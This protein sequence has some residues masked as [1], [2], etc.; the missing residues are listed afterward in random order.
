MAEKKMTS[1]EWSLY[2][3]VLSCSVVS[4]LGSGFICYM[5]LKYERLQSFPYVLVFFLAASDLLNAIALALPGQVA[6]VPAICTLQATLH[7]VSSLSSVLWTGAIPYALWLIITKDVPGDSGWVKRAFAGFTC[8]ALA[9]GLLPVVFDLYG[10]T[11]LWCWIRETSLLGSIMVFATYYVFLVTVFV[12]SIVFSCLSVT[13][14][15][16]Q[17]LG[18]ASRKY[19]FKKAILFPI[20]TAVAILP[21]FTLRVSYLL[22]WT[23]SEPL[24][25]IAAAFYSLWGAFNAIVYGLSHNVRQLLWGRRSVLIDETASALT[26]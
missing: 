16:K 6:A 1:L 22:G 25:F 5:F 8:L 11:G 2:V 9:A 26:N 4:M 12:E 7:G 10:P 20:V 19:L 15:R 17:R 21:V 24:F 13:A 18:S 14:L 3:T 23:Q